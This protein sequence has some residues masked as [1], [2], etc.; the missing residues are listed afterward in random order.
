MRLFQSIALIVKAYP[1][2]IAYILPWSLTPVHLVSAATLVPLLDRLNIT[3]RFL[4]LFRFI[5]AFQRG[6]KSYISGGDRKFED[7]LDILSAS[8]LGIYGL[9]E[10]A[11]LLDLIGIPNLT[12]FEVAQAKEL[13]RQAQ[14][15]WFTALYAASVSAGIKLLRVLAYR[16]VPTASATFGTGDEKSAAKSKKKSEKELL[17][18]SL[19]KRVEERKAEVKEFNA[20][21]VTL[22]LT[23]VV[24]LLDMII[25]AVAV[26][27]VRIEPG[28]VGIAMLVTTLITTRNVWI[29]CGKDLES[30]AK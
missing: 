28:Y 29:K 1:F 11:T 10:S 27:W 21:V 15:Y 23:M 3:R 6:W 16:A 14:I 17:K 24:S 12:F 22:S 2:L 4:R 19:E 7:W 26:G 30:R 9:I 18:E 25:P 13:N 5:E 8:T 20:K